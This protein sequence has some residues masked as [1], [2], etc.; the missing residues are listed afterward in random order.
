MARLL[1]TIAVGIVLP[2]VSHAALIEWSF[3]D[4]GFLAGGTASGSFVYDTSDGSIGSASAASVGDA[5]GALCSVIGTPGD[6]ICDAFTLDL[7]FAGKTY[8]SGFGVGGAVLLYG[9]ESALLLN[10]AGDLGT[11][12]AHNVDLILEFVCTDGIACAFDVEQDFFR[13]HISTS[14]GIGTI[15][16][17]PEPSTLALLG[18]GLLGIGLTRRARG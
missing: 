11:P 3:N 1:L 16:S 4:L 5:S 10:F 6:G 15:S 17:V 13:A 18:L 2:S 14:D 12:G 9:A 7:A 8:D